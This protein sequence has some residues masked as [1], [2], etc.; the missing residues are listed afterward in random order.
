MTLRYSATYDAIA[1]ETAFSA[2]TASAPGADTTTTAN[3]Y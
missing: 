3:T 2:A 1:A